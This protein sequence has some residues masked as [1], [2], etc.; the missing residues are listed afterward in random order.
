M[1]P[2]HVPGP[3]K[4]AFDKNRPISDLIRA[5]VNHLK[6]IEASLPAEPAQRNSH[7]TKSPPSPTQQATSPR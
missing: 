3:P 4:Q 6:H 2:I 5:Q 1:D 7:H